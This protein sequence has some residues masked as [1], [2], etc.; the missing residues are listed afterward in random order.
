MITNNSL[1][2]LNRNDFSNIIIS[3]KFKFKN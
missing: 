1:K 3:N 2:E